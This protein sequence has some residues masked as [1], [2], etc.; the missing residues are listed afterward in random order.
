MNILQDTRLLPQSPRQA[1]R[2]RHPRPTIRRCIREVETLADG[3]IVSNLKSLSKND[4]T[5]YETIIDPHTGE[6]T[7]TCP[8]HTFRGRRCKHLVRAFENASRK[9]QLDEAVAALVGKGL[10]VFPASQLDEN[11][12]VQATDA[13]Y[14]DYWRSLSDEE[15]TALAPP[16]FEVTTPQISLCAGC[17]EPPSVCRCWADGINAEW[18]AFAGC[19][20]TP[21]EVT[22]DYEGWDDW[23]AE[24][25]LEWAEDDGPTQ[26]ANCTC[27]RHFPGGDGDTKCPKCKV[28]IREAW[29]RHFAKQNEEDSP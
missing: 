26:S 25:D 13:E 16:V 23:G 6:G 21:E 5:Q 20:K 9:S 22:E 7:C 19:D 1:A 17:F 24:E 11:G 10:M 12:P 18:E 15:L 27:G 3:K 14:Q 29:D 28:T 4:G 2:T 8:D